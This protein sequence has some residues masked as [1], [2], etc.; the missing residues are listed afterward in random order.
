[1]PAALLA[2]C[3]KSASEI[4][5]DA[6]RADVQHA[7]DA[8]VAENAR[9]AEEAKVIAEESAK[10]KA[11]RDAE[12]A[13]RQSEQ[14]AADAK[15]QEEW[16]ANAKTAFFDPD[17]VKYQGIRWNTE[18]SAL[19]GQVNAKNK[20]GGYVGFKDVVILDGIAFVNT[21]DAYVMYRS[22]KDRARCSE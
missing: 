11:S 19:C 20:M 5:A 21:D 1:M 6:K 16:L 2:G 9:R 10:M 13:A 4:A 22:A 15:R 3:G 17:S 8:I 12:D 7:N 18:H 14:A